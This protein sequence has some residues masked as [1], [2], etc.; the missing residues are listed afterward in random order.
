MRGGYRPMHSR[1]YEIPTPLHCE[2]GGK[3]LTSWCPGYPFPLVLFPIG[4]VSSDFFTAYWPFGQK[5]RQFYNS[6]TENTCDP[7]FEVLTKLSMDK[8]KTDD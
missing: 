4:W 3:E 7:L 5:T 2:L 8:I 6:T 1:P